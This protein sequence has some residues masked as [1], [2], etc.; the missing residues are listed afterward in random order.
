MEQEEL[1]EHLVA[2]SGIDDFELDLKPKYSESYWGRYYPNRK[3]I[4]IY[5]LDEDGEEYDES[6]L[7]KESLHELTHHIQY[8]HVEGWERKSGVM[9]DNQFYEIFKQLLDIAF[10]RE[11]T[12]HLTNSGSDRIVASRK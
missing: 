7:L 6:T 8:N 4:V 2:I 10:D 11:M 1:Q 5:Q 12:I 3:R 9:H